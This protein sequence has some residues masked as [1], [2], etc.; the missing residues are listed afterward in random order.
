[1][2]QL[3]Y[4]RLIS[5]RQFHQ[6]VTKNMFLP[7]SLSIKIFSFPVHVD[8]V[9]FYSQMVLVCCSLFKHLKVVVMR[10]RT[11]DWRDCTNIIQSYAL[12]LHSDP[13]SD[14]PHYRSLA[15]SIHDLKSA[16]YLNLKSCA[17]KMILKWVRSQDAILTMAFCDFKIQ[18]LKS[19]K[20]SM[21]WR[22]QKSD[23]GLF[24]Q[25][26]NVP[27]KPVQTR[28]NFKISRVSSSV[29]IIR[30]IH[31]YSSIL[32]FWPRRINSTFYMKMDIKYG[33]YV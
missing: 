28:I 33:Y 13:V 29:I 4:Q 5:K 10:R 26:L 22:N 6:N 20:H 14:I 23:I 17:F 30:M 11:F 1:M 8:Q 32:R 19:L 16:V 7:K 24:W 12:T 27:R 18:E 15:P 2:Q 9:L 25:N 21:L 31:D 3:S